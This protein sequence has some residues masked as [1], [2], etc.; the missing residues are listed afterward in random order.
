MYLTQ[1]PIRTEF[2]PHSFGGT[3][4]RVSRF[5]NI[6][7]IQIKFPIGSSIRQ[8]RRYAGRSKSNTNG[9]FRNITQRRASR[10]AYAAQTN[11]QKFP[12]TRWVVRVRMR[13]YRRG[14]SPILREDFGNLKTDRRCFATNLYHN[15]G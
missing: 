4:C 6:A 9:D 7:S 5:R 2:V 11:K 13:H 15:I 10:A 8:Q 1:L 14:G 3:A 12:K